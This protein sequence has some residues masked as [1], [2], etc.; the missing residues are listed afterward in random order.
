MNRSFLPT[1]VSLAAVAVCFVSYAESPENPP[2]AESQKLR[3]L[4][5]TGGCCH[6]YKMQKEILTSGLGERLAIDW[7]VVHEPDRK[8]AH[9]HQFEMLKKDDWGK[10]YDF[11]LYNICFAKEEDEE[12]IEGITQAHKDGL[13]AVA[14]HCTMHS[15]HWNTE[16]KEWTR[17]LGVSSRGHGPKKAYQVTPIAKHPILEGFPESWQ[18]PAGELYNVQKVLEGT[19][20]IAEGDNGIKKQPVMWVNEYGKARVFC[21]T[22]GHHNETMAEPVYLDTLA[23]GV[24][25][26]TEKNRKE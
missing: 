9:A 3:G 17:F 21:S 19:V 7:T 11:V 25:W 1:L 8:K 13:P 14:L 26:V 23:R 16:K 15:H 6:D 20:V 2:E 24:R 22:I 5:L 10:D 12:Y 4:H 18:T